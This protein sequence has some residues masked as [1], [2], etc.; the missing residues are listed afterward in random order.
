VSERARLVQE[1]KQAFPG[2]KPNSTDTAFDIPVNTRSGLI[3]V[4]M[5][6]PMGFPDSPPT[7]VSRTPIRHHLFNTHMQYQIRH[8]N[9]GSRCSLILETLR[10]FIKPAPWISLVN[11]LK[12]LIAE[13]V[14]TPPVLLTNNA[15]RNPTYRSPITYAAPMAK[16]MPPPQ[17]FTPAPVVQ[18]RPRANDMTVEVTPKPRQ[19]EYTPPRIDTSFYMLDGFN[20]EELRKLLSSD[21]KKDALVESLGI[22]SSGD[23]KK[24]ELYTEVE[25]LAEKNLRQKPDFEIKRDELEKLRTKE[26]EMREKLVKLSASQNELQKKFSVESL[27]KQLS[28]LVTAADEAS[29]EILQKYNDSEMELDAYIKEYIKAR[30]LFHRRSA[31]QER[32]NLMNN[33]GNPAF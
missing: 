9:R 19:P 31:K 24:E 2:A 15:N 4:Q 32:I 13:L 22:F 11:L 17:P 8:W 5:T 18:P 14:R 21:E 25:D 1:F 10:L 28:S 26:Q 29:E 30:S 6:L 20:T 33:N 27:R 3:D 16:P 23:K 12:S 7:F